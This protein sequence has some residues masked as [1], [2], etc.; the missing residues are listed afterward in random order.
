MKKKIKK[1]VKVNHKAKKKVSR[2]RGVTKDMLLTDVMKKYPSS[3]NIMFK[4]GLHCMGC[5]AS[6]GETIEEGCRSHLMGEEDINSLIREIN[7]A[8]GLIPKSKKVIKKDIPVV[9]PKVIVQDFKP[10]K[11][12]V[13]PKPMPKLELKKRGF[14]SRLFSKKKGDN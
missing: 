8:E 7:E 11:A 14:F 1:K 6:S 4:Y 12:P 5:Q 2:V 9:K 3:I 13:L 10:Q